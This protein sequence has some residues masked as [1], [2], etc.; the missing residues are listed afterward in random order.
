MTQDSY[1][2]K[3]A[4]IGNEKLAVIKFVKERLGNSL[5]ES[6]AL[7]ESCDAGKAVVIKAGCSRDEAEDLK[8]GLIAVG[9]QAYIE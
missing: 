1:V 2:V 4:D 9:A 7:V 3:L 5:S 8:M 6:K